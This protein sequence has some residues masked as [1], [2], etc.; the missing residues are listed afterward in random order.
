MSFSLDLSA[1][2]GNHANLIEERAVTVALAAHE[3]SDVMSQYYLSCLICNLSTSQ[4]NHTALADGAVFAVLEHLSDIDDMDVYVQCIIGLRNLAVMD[5]HKREIVKH[6]GLNILLYGFGLEPLEL[7]LCRHLIACLNN[8]SSLPANKL[9]I[10][11]KEFLPILLK[12]LF[13]NDEQVVVQTCSTLANLAELSICQNIIATS[14][15]V[16][17][18]IVL[19]RSKVVTIQCEAGRL[20]SNICSSNESY[21]NY[22]LDGGGHNLFVSFLL[23]PSL[24]HQRVG[25]VGLANLTAHRKYHKPLMRSGVLGPFISTLRNSEVD[26][27]VQQYVLM[28]LSSTYQ[29]SDTTTICLFIILPYL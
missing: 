29:L 17:Q 13:Y 18:G 14:E 12:L 19:M 24:P 23:S 1:T 4:A 28:A 7:D 3:T 21:V 27:Y 5:A 11:Q 8:L 22:I 25:V 2:P 15:I 16:R 9:D 6:N 26:P 10:V 20:I